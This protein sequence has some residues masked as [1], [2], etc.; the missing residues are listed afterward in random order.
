M[1]GIWSVGQM[2]LLI[3]RG[4]T[5]VQEHE[6]KERTLRIGRGTQNDIVLED[7]GKGVSRHHAEIRFDGGRYT[8]VDLQSQNG[9]WVSGTRVPSVGLEPGITAALGPFRLMMQVPPPVSAIVAAPA[10]PADPATELTQLS[11]RTAAPLNLDSLSQ[12]VE[13]ASPPKPAAEKPAAKPPEKAPAAK[14]VAEK[15]P[16]APAQKQTAVQ[17]TTPPP[18]QK[19]ATSEKAWYSNSRTVGPIAVV[20]LIGLS[21]VIGYTLMRNRTRQAWD[22]AAAQQ[23]IASG[24]CQQALDTQITPALQKNPNDA[25]ALMLRDQCNKPPE[26]VAATSTI[27]ATPSAPSVSDR[28]NEAD[29]L[30]AGNVVADCQ[31][32]LDTANAVLTEDPNNERAKD[33]S[34]RATACVNPP[35]AA[36]KPPAATAEKLATPISPAQGGLEV[37][38][39]ETEKAYKA[40]V[41]IM[42]KKYDDAVAVLATQKYQQALSLFNELVPEVPSGY[43]ELAQKR[44]EARAGVRAE[45]KA[46]LDAA[47]AADKRD[48]YDTAIDQYRR[49]HQLDPSLQIDAAVQRVIERKVALGRQKCSEGKVAFSLGDSATAGP[50]L[51]EAVRLLQGTNDPCYATARDYLQKLNK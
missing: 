18:A 34:T 19:T 36:T 48:N 49:A 27:P 5:Q 42:N 28:L 30:L 16:A 26:P 2:K 31:K 11:S 23:L 14:P 47:Q 45:A 32:A 33:L 8:L 46:L 20:L 35:P 38:Q 4:E 12:P 37:T 51:Q 44:D 9:I 39:G 10:I 7:P 1:D 29:A 13:K 50:A 24:K 43:R 6:L 15:A 17:K 21:A 40:R 22:P 25:R 41:A 3:F